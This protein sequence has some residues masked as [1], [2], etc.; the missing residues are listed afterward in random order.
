M[1]HPISGIE[2]IRGRL[3][4]RQDQ[5]ALAVLGVTP[6]EAYGATN[7]WQQFLHTGIGAKWPC[8]A[9]DSF[10]AVWDSTIAYVSAAG[11]KTGLASYAAWNDGDRA[12]AE[13]LW[14]IVNHARPQTI[15]ETGVAHGITSRVILEGLHR[16]EAGHLWSVDLPATDPRLH[17][18]IGMAVPESL[19]SRWTYVAGTSRR[20]LP[21]IRRNV[22]HLDLFL[23]D[24]LHTQRNLCFELDVAWPALRMG[25]VAVVDDIDHNLGFRDFVRR[26]S[27]AWIAARHTTG[28]GLWG[29]AIKAIDRT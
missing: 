20:K 15:V 22:E 4:R 18:E 8:S 9:K 14:C 6:T 5:R 7:D 17:G 26:A 3:D 11:L 25:G 10:S 13:A 24:S 1:R 16:N 23:H 21:R 27:P 12:Q 19:R 28:N 2:R 29:I